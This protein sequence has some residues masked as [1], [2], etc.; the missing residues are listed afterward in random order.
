MGERSLKRGPFTGSTKDKPKRINWSW[1]IRK[2]LT[3]NLQKPSS[4]PSRVSSTQRVALRVSLLL[5]REN[6]LAMEKETL[7]KIT[8]VKKKT[9]A[10]REK[11]LM[12]L[13]Q[14]N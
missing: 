5:T 11:P 1:V 4:S 8:K 6:S 12:T 13:L 2:K 10:L 14:D 7:G 9:I 3:P